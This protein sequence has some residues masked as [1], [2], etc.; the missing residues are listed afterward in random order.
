MAIWYGGQRPH[1]R[2]KWD[3]SAVF[4][5]GSREDAFNQ[6]GWLFYV[7]TWLTCMSQKALGVT[8]SRQVRRHL[9]GRQTPE[10]T[11]RHADKARSARTAC[12]SRSFDLR[13]S[14]CSWETVSTSIYITDYPQQPPLHGSFNVLLVYRS[15]WRGASHS[16]KIK[17]L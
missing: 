11:R 15:Q 1:K 4:C 10:A 6:V 7:A 16:I 13:R 8:A 3:I 17:Y 14:F 9:S 5:S 12:G 2:A